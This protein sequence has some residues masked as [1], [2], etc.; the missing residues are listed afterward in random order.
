M[1]PIG[2][3]S[4]AGFEG[5]MQAIQ[6]KMQA[7]QLQKAMR[8]AENAKINGIADSAAK[9]GSAASQIKVQY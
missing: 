6:A 5:G 4:G 9:A 2:M 8:D 1:N 3:I 7:D